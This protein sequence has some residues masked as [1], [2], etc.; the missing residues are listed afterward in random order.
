MEATTH[1]PTESGV[2]ADDLNNMTIVVVGLVSTALVLASAL[3]IKAL[4]ST[5]VAM[6]SEKKANIVEYTEADTV[7]MEQDES[8]YGAPR[9]MAGKSGV[10]SLP[11]NQAMDLV[12]EELQQKQQQN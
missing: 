4:F 3:G 8:L 1:P 5:Y 2:E 9:E 12:V 7:L 6:D 10:Y 11:I